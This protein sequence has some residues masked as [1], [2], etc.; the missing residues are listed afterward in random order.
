MS[1]LNEIAARAEAAKNKT[2]YDM[3]KVPYA[4]PYGDIQHLLNV[5]ARQE[6]ALERVRELANDPKAVGYKPEAI[7]TALGDEQ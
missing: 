3:H 1:R 4:N 7:R 5:V 6:Q 2:F